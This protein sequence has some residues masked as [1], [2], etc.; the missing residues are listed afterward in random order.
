MKRF[1][2][3]LAIASLCAMSHAGDWGKAPVGKT[4]VEECR[5][6]GGSLA[7]GYESDFIYKG[8]LVGGQ[9]AVGNLQYQIE[10]LPLP[11]QFGVNYT[12]VIS[13]NEFAN[14]FDDEL[15]VS[16]RVSLPSLAGI[17]TSVSYTQRFYTENPNTP[18]WPS[19]SGEVG[20]H[21]SKDLKVLLLKYNAY[22]NFNVPNAWNGTIPTLDNDESGAWYW[23]ITAERRFDVAG[24]PFVIAGGV[25]FADNY[26]GSAPSAETGGRSSGW[27]HY[28]LRASMPLE[29]NCRTLV[30]PYVGYLGAPEG[31]LMDGAP[32]WANRPAQSD[33]LHG[34]VNFKVDF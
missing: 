25:A 28:F 22:Y 26:W 33:L 8:L 34:G 12:N 29:V 6:L 16:G 20:L 2:P 32:D 11:V 3:T 1:L 5:D 18:L 21:L 15:A 13:Q 30:T 7:L 31:W 19:S 14:V 17:E 23:D 24:L 27:N 4:S 10:G 9:S